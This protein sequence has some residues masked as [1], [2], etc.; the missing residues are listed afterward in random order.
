MAEFDDLGVDAWTPQDQAYAD[1]SD[2]IY[3][4]NRSVF[5]FPTW[6]QLQAAEGDLKQYENPIIIVDGGDVPE[7]NLTTACSLIAYLGD[8]LDKLPIRSIYFLTK[9]DIS[10]IDPLVLPPQRKIRIKRDIE[11][12]VQAGRK[13]W[14]TASD[15]SRPALR[16]RLRTH[17]TDILK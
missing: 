6:T 14:E 2:I 16:G 7:K 11:I 10:S 4:K 13:R 3:L 17:P 15:L 1:L 5:Y 9:E 12:L 8:Q